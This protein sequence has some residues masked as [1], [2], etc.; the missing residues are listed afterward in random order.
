MAGPARRRTRFADGHDRQDRVWNQNSCRTSAPRDEEGPAHRRSLSFAHQYSVSPKRRPWPMAR[1]WPP[2][3]R[4]VGA[5]R[6]I[7]RDCAGERRPSG[8]PTADFRTTGIGTLLALGIPSE[9]L[10][11]GSLFCGHACERLKGFGA[12]RNLTAA[13]APPRQSQHRS[14]QQAARYYNDAEAR[15]GSARRRGCCCD[16]SRGAETFRRSQA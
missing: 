15:L 14:V 3:R 13:A 4:H 10:T 12:P 6:N 16:I 1:S 11:A 8:H 5:R 2:C 9:F 7:R